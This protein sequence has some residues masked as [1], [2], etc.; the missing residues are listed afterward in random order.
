M[1]FHGTNIA[2]LACMAR[3]Q[4]RTPE[5]QILEDIIRTMSEKS[6]EILK[7]WKVFEHEPEAELFAKFNSS[8]KTHVIPFV[9]TYKLCGLSNICLD[10]TGQGPWAGAGQELQAEPTD[11]V[12][13]L[14]PGKDLEEFLSQLAEAG[15]DAVAPAL[16]KDWKHQVVSLL[17]AT[18]RTILGEYL[19]TNPLC[20]K[21]ELCVYSSMSPQKVIGKKRD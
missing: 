5:H 4:I 6:W 16:K 20:G 12:Y 3:F 15:C 9:R 21:T 11:L 19:Y 14:F 2:K 7:A 18:F 8:L 13:H 1:E 17:R 10:A